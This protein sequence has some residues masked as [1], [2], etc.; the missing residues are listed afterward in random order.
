MTN[1]QQQLRRLHRVEVEGLFGIYN[2]CIDLKLNP[3]VT[4][5]HGPNGVGKTTILKMVDAMLKKYISYFQSVPFERLSL[6]FDDGAALELTKDGPDL[7]AGKITLNANSKHDSTP[8]NLAMSPAERIGLEV[9]YLQQISKGEWIDLRDDELL[10][11]IQV[12]RRYGRSFSPYFP[13]ERKLTDIT[14]TQETDAPWLS[15][16]LGSTESYFIEAQ[17][18]VRSHHHFPNW[19]EGRGKPDSRV[20][21]CSKDLKRRI[22]ETMVDYGRHAQAL[23]Q[24]FPQRLLQHGAAINNLSNDEIKRRMSAIDNKT[25]ELK[26]MGILVG[27]L[28]ETPKFESVNSIDDSQIGVMTLY[29]DDTEKKLQVLEDLSNRARLLLNNL[30]SKFRYKKLHIDRDKGLSVNGENGDNSLSLDSLSSG[31]QHELILHY[32][33]LFRV[34]RNT[35]VL[36]DE[37]ELSLHIEWQDKFLPDL[38]ETIQLCE[39]DALVATHSPYIVG[40]N[41]DLMIEL[42][43]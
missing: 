42:V 27:V 15:D 7:D 36:L 24:S 23:D 41:D 9:E 1:E 8:I 34:P 31:E 18:L 4:L 2:H 33:L 37:P 12:V 43:G 39:F 16:F 35:I 28:D 10:T 19:H 20:I 13:A 38:K 29:V 14:N 17:R 5:L 30:N 32:N 6:S 22:D 3:R 25:E 11:D 26:K 40:S 21:E